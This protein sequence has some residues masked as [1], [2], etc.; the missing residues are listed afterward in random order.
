MKYISPSLLDARLIRLYWRFHF[1]RDTTF[2]QTVEG[3]ESKIQESAT[4]RSIRW[5]CE[6]RFLEFRIGIG[7]VPYMTGFH[8]FPVLNPRPHEILEAMK[9][10]VDGIYVVNSISIIPIPYI[11]VIVERD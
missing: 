11:P 9:W 8:P 7:N 2:A 4:E 3:R 6:D 1:H 10:L 5:E